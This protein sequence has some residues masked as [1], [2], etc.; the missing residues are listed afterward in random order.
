MEKYIYSPAGLVPPLLHLTPCTPIKSN[1]YFH[2][3]FAT[4]MN[5]PALYR[6]LTFHVPNFVSI[7][8]SLVRLSKES[9]Q[10]GALC[11]TS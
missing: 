4:V 10:F 3:S 6:L 7:S 5:E 1:I 8:L 9:V 11:D 2:I